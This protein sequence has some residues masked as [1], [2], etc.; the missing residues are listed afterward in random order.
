MYASHHRESVYCV[1]FNTCRQSDFY[2]IFASGSKDGTVA[3]WDLYK[4]N[5]K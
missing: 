2:G 4:N 5:L 3:L 1:E